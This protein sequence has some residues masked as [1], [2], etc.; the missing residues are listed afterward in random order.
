MVFFCVITQN[1]ISKISSTSELICISGKSTHWIFMLESSR[2]LNYKQ[3][4]THRACDV[5]RFSSPA[6]CSQSE[7]VGCAWRIQGTPLTFKTSVGLAMADDRTPERI[8]QTTL[9]RRVSSVNRD[10]SLDFSHTQS[11]SGNSGTGVSHSP[12]FSS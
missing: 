1:L 6:H 2:H 3:I 7:N 9:I 12:T 11:A 10:V 5:C 4:H 8:P